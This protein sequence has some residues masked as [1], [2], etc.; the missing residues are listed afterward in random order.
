MPMAWMPALMLVALL[1]PWLTTAAAPRDRAGWVAL[2]RGGFMVPD[3]ERA[4]DLLVE[5]VPLLAS[6][7]PVLRD[8]V[9]Y[10]AAERWI[11]RD[12]RLDAADVRR[13]A[14]L[15][16]AQLDRGLGERGSDSVLGRSFAALCLSLVAANDL[17]SAALPPG[18]VAGLFDH[19]LA[20]LAAERDVRGFEPGRG[21]LHS[22]AHTA[23][24]LKFLARNPRLPAGADVRL[25]E[26]IRAKLDASEAVFTWGENDRLAWALHAAVRRGDATPAALE[27]WTAHWTAAHAALW[28]DGPQVDA[29]RFAVVENAAQV[30]RGLVTA[31][32][33]DA[34]PTPSGEAAR[35]TLLA[36]LGRMR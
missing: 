8:E 36:A 13:M 18:E 2:A 10:A 17:S 3:G 27:A 4:V 9:A 20:Y 25:L 33:L 32:S 34:A 6:P 35:R 7:D 22:V 28:K 29:R 14:G 1:P 11:L 15:W 26:G 30:M 16:R 5:M 31:L 21:W 19:A 23:D 24:L 12:R